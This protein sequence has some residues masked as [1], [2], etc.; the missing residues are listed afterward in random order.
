MTFDSVGPLESDESR[1]VLAGRRS[2][3]GQ[4]RANPQQREPRSDEEYRA[5]ENHASRGAALRVVV[6]EDGEGGENLNGGPT[7]GCLFHSVMFFGKSSRCVF[8]TSHIMASLYNI[9][10]S[11]KRTQGRCTSGTP[12]GRVHPS[13]MVFPTRMKALIRSRSAKHLSGRGFPQ[14][15]MS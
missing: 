9:T 11:F 13:Y 15:M 3:P 7:R 2:L 12:F 1:I 14:A 6:A 5:G 10:I 4:G 8:D